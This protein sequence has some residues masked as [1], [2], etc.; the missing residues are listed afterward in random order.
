VEKYFSAGQ[1]TDDNMA[2]AHY[3]LAKA[4]N[5]QS[6]YVILLF[7]H[8]NNGCRNGPKYY[9]MR[10]LPLLLFITLE[11]HNLLATQKWNFSSN[12]YAIQKAF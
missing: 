11:K 9:V 1:V 2:H 7:L 10:T 3:T 8:C 5:T 4:T 12:L 6:E